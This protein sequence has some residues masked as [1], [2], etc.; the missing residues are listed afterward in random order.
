[1]PAILL[2]W[3]LLPLVLLLIE[4]TDRIV[5]SI[6]D[7]NEGTHLVVVGDGPRALRRWFEE[8]ERWD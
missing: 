5:F 3:L 2:C 1:V 6:T 4:Q 8:L 7:R